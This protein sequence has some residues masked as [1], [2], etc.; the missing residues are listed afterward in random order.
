M[1]KDRG[2]QGIDA[3]MRYHPMDKPLEE[4]RMKIRLEN[5]ELNLKWVEFF[6]IYVDSLL[7]FGL[8]GVDPF[9]GGGVELSL[10]LLLPL[11]EFTCVPPLPARFD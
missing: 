7:P 5:M 6:S 8:P 1:R 4:R 3:Y 11:N 2:N 9:S 10:S